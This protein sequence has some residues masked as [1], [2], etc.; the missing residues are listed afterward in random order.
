MEAMGAVEGAPWDVGSLLLLLLRVL[1][2]RAGPVGALGTFH[3]S[4]PVLVGEHMV[5]AGVVE[6]VGDVEVAG[7]MGEAVQTTA[8]VPLKGMTG[9]GS[10]QLQGSFLGP[11][12]ETRGHQGPHMA[13]PLRETESPR[14]SNTCWA[15]GCTRG[16]F[17]C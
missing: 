2:S 17:Q 13:I 6:H 11:H 12:Q 10:S 4:V 8:K 3:V 15:R 5:V 14:D 7:A 1:E 16:W 9:A